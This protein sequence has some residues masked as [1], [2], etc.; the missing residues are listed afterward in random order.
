MDDD[1]PCEFCWQCFVCCLFCAKPLPEPLLKH[2]TCGWQKLV[3]IH[4]SVGI[5]LIHTVVSVLVLLNL[6]GLSKIKIRVGYQWAILSPDSS[7]KTYTNCTLYFPSICVHLPD[8]LKCYV[9]NIWTV[10]WLHKNFSRLSL[11]HKQRYHSKK[12]FFIDHLPVPDWMREETHFCL[13]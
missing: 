11:A 7:L 8:D 13:L 3:I 12:L 10:F 5:L 9:R 2:W 1:A 6:C 4:I